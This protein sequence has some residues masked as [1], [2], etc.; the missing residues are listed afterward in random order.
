[1]FSKVF[2]ACQPALSQRGWLGIWPNSVVLREDLCPAVGYAVGDE[3]LGYNVIA[4]K[5]NL[6]L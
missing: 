3:Q 5:E 6:K 2:E 1:M 4:E